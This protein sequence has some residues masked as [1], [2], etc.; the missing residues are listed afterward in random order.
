M[1]NA[2]ET[3]I[4]ESSRFYG[5][6]E[7]VR[8]IQVDEGDG[9]YLGTT[10]K[11]VIPCHNLATARSYIEGT[12]EYAIANRY[13]GVARAGRS[14]QPLIECIGFCS[15]SGQY[16]AVVQMPDMDI[17]IDCHNSATL[18]GWIRDG[19]GFQPLIEA[20][21]DETNVRPTGGWHG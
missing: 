10:R 4:Q 7:V 13:Q 8:V 11:E 3:Y 15:P 21:S 1:N 19:I 16:Y 6:Y 14:E 20:I 12:R 17:R 9:L 5:K 18:R 2:I